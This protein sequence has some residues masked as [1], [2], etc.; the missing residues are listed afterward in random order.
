[1]LYGRKEY[2]AKGCDWPCRAASITG[3][4]DGK[5]LGLDLEEGQSAVFATVLYTNQESMDYEKRCEE[6]LAKL[7]GETL[8][9]LKRVHEE[10][11]RDFW[12]ES[13]ISI[14]S[15]PLSERYWYLS[16][17]L[18]ACCCESGKYA[19]GLFGN[20]VTTDEPAWCGDYHLN[21][22]YEAPWWGL[23][24]SNHI[25]LSDPYDQP[26]LDYMPKSE[27]AA[28]RK[29]DCSG[30]YTLVG[31]GPRGLRT[32]ALETKDGKDDVNYWGQKSNAAYA[33][34]N[35][36]MRFYYTYDR[37]YAVGTAYPYLDKTADFWLDYLKWDG[38]RYVIQNDSIHENPAS[39]RG[40]FDW[41]DD[42]V[43]DHSDDCN[44]ILS[45][46]LLRTLFRGLLDICE[47]FG[48]ETEKR[49]KWRHVL[50]HLSDFPTMER[51]G[52]TVFRLTESGMEWN[53]GNSLAIL[54]VLKK[55][56]QDRLSSQSTET[57]H[58]KRR[59]WIWNR[60]AQTACGL[61]MNFHGS[62]CS[63]V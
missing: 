23:F 12:E 16:H 63:A 13:S 27:Q 38:Q 9:Q 42:N 7:N 43:P 6:E 40:V 3:V 37:D 14:P 59:Y 61:W 34:I 44:P 62:G 45:L 51:G 20:W 22:N 55:D 58:D 48:L 28:R 11:W 24:S 1:M 8:L 19:P 5:G 50:E 32:A 17:Y 39:A 49:E 18:M 25:S 46:G 35:M 10:W 41:A 26:L 53:D 56:N 2:D 60:S 36:L 54:S 31:I 29:L 4:L 21:Y 30:L 15:E 47:T 52:R 57:S 33:A